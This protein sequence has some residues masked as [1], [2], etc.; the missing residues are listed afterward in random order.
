MSNP[1]GPGPVPPGTPNP[2]GTSAPGPNPFGTPAPGGTPFGVPQDD[3]FSFDMTGVDLNA[4]FRIPAGDYV[5][6]LVALEKG[7]SKAGN[8][9]WIWTFAITHGEYAGKEFKLFTALTP[10]AAWKVAETLLALGL[11]E[12]GS[13]VKFKRQDALN[14]RCILHIVDDTYN[15]QERSTLEKILPHPDGPGPEQTIPTK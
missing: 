7:T 13:S 11:G 12:A 6:K 3:D 14:R 10:A 2:F 15:G 9:Q 1:T 8:P 4:N 5:G